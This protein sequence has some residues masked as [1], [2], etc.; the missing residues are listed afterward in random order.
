MGAIVQA[1]RDIAFSGWI[2]VELD[3][4]PD[5]REGAASSMAFLHKAEA[6]S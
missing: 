6:Q 4:W 1:L 3:S 2:T 5:P